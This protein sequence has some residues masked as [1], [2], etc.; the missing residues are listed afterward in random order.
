MMHGRKWLLATLCLAAATSAGAAADEAA[1]R[2]QI[3]QQSQGILFPK[4]LLSATEQADYRARIR[5]A[6]TPEELQR[7]H[8]EHYA[9]MKIRAK[10]MGVDLP[11]T[12]P[13]A[14]FS[15][16]LI[17]EEQRAAQRAKARSARR[18]Q[19]V[20]I[21]RPSR[22]QALVVAGDKTPAQVTQVTPSGT[23]PPAAALPAVRTLPG[24]FSIFGPQLMTEE[25][26][27]AFRAR[28]RKAG[29]DEERQAIRAERAQL[30]RQRAR[31]QGVTPP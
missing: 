6:K 25:E 30:L 17:T 20:E 19:A 9:L 4:P 16:H 3:S 22:G 11:D 2:A 15:P 18:E 10:Q 1:H 29:S 14:S 26:K 5:A 13:S 8:A 27:A 21:V 23:T 12:P 7:V 28:L 31:Q 24:V